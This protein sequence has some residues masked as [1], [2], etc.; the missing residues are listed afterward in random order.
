[1]PPQVEKHESRVQRSCTR[2]TLGTGLSEMPCAIGVTPEG[3]ILQPLQLSD[4]AQIP[5]PEREEIPDV[6]AFVQQLKTLQ[7]T[8]VC[9]L[10][11]LLQSN[12][13]I[14]VLSVGRFLILS[15]YN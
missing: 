6:D 14:S 4:E 1:M 15:H 11:W 12:P 3:S 2:F 13:E 5:L 10:Y 7:V 9:V 8:Y